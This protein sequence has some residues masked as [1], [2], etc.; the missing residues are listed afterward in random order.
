V[1][2]GREGK[3]SDPFCGSRTAQAAIQHEV[4]VV[5]LSALNPSALVINFRQTGTSKVLSVT[6][7]KTMKKLA[8][9]I[10]ASVLLL[11]SMSCGWAPWDYPG[12]VPWDRYHG[13]GYGYGYP[14]R[15]PY[16]YHDHDEYS[17]SDAD[18]AVLGAV[19]GTAA[20]IGT[21]LVVDA[22]RNQ[23]APQPAPPPAPSFN[24]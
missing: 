23:P 10:L 2:K 20:V 4:A 9:V 14:G 6:E 19:L 16:P 11:P 5:W 17:D 12:P 18:A 13:H 21:V 7:G 3:G 24:P 15:Y 8:G 1:T 22:I